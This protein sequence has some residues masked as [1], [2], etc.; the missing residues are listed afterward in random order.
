MT[1]NLFPFAWKIQQTKSPV[2]SAKHHQWWQA[3]D[4]AFSFLL[5]VIKRK[6]RIKSDLW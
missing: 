3:L 6:K 5:W 4:K 2:K 1:S